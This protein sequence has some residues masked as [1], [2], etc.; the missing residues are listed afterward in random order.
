MFAKLKRFLGDSVL[1]AFMSLSTKLIAFMMM[2]LYSEY[3]DRSEVGI[4]GTVD[5]TIAMFTFL[6]IFGTDSA[7]A[8]YYFEEKEKDRKLLYVRNVM[9]FR[10]VVA[11]VLLLLVWMIGSPLVGLLQQL[12]I[13][14]S[15]QTTLSFIH[16]L[17]ISMFTLLADTIIVLVLTVLRYEMKSVQVVV[18]TVLKMGLIAVITYFMLVYASHSLDSIFYARLI[19]VGV[20]LLLIGKSALKYLK[21]T[22]NKEVLRDLLKYSAPLVPASL[23]FW[24]IGNSN[25]YLLAALHPE[26]T[27]AVGIYEMAFR[28]ASMI[29]LL[30]YGIQMAW[31]PY[32]MQLKNKENSEQMFAKIYIIIFAVGVVGI[33]LVALCM[34]FIIQILNEKFHAAF[35]Y[36]GFLSLATFINFYYLIIS[37][38]LLFKKETKQISYAFGLGAVISFVLNISM[39]PLFGI[40][41]SIIANLLTYV[42]ATAYIFYRSQKVYYIPVSTGKLLFIFIQ[43]CIALAGL[44][45]I[46]VNP[47]IAGY[48]QLVPVVYLVAS[49]LIS[50]IDR[51]FRLQ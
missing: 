17:N 39:I 16:A 13:L 24:V 51:D 28:F 47:Q 3:L 7:L 21:I 9:G 14:T 36:V 45:Y 26:G 30:T 15:S 31:R 22:F 18:Y 42:F 25:R 12:G 1:Y 35:P 11:L 41:G 46:Q 43:A 10:L 32:S 27:E 2:P 37:S 33:F 49:L 20:V 6:I 44:T 4:V 48:Y 40:W 50:R 8:F 5:S 23:A 29:S 38:G 34:P 19:G